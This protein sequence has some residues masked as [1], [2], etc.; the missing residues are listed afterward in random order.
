MTGWL[1]MRPPTHM[2]NGLS[3][4]VDGAERMDQTVV[5][6][7]NQLIGRHKFRDISATWSLSRVRDAQRSR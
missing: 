4:Y 7:R 1:G 3:V 2:I 5:F 6:F